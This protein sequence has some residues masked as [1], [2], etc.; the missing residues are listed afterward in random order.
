MRS[1]ALFVK[2]DY[3]S[4]RAFAVDVVNSDLF[5]V[6]KIVTNR[7]RGLWREVVDAPKGTALKVALDNLV[8]YQNR[9]K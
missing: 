5:K 7:E 6:S 9:R 8:K 1:S 2:D 4:Q 3:E